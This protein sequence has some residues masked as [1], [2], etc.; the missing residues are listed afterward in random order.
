M[1]DTLTLQNEYEVRGLVAARKEKMP[2]I[3]TVQKF[4]RP[5][6]P[7]LPPGLRIF[8]TCKSLIR[9]ISRYK[10]PEGTEARDPG[11]EPVKKDDHALDALRYAL[12]TPY[13][14]RTPTRRPGGVSV[15]TIR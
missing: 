9:E 10:W 13:G 8:N 14:A 2:G 5:V 1:A 15:T 12:H 11:N 4:L 6:A 7:G 3:A